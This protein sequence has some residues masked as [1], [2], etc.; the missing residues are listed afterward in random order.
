ML[1][2]PSEELPAPAPTPPQ[3][4]TSAIALGA[5]LAFA[6]AIGLVVGLLGRPILIHDVPIQ[7]VVTVVPDRSDGQAMT[8]APVS[9]P[10]NPATSTASE[11][12]QE[13]TQA[14][15]KA[16]SAQ[17][18]TSASATPTLME[19]V[20]ADARHFQGDQTAPVTII[21]FSDFK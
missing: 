8:E 18:E 4:S 2:Y 1:E 20:L 5:A 9:S 3:S 15:S 6:F 7:V 11:A 12:P 16:G 10:A 19:F 14:E 13:A 17:A 21:E